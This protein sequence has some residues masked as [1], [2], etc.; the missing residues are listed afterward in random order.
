MTTDIP[1]IN[2][3]PISDVLTALPREKR[4][5]YQ[6][7]RDLGWQ[8]TSYKDALWH[9]YRVAIGEIEDEPPAPYN[10]RFPPRRVL[11]DQAEREEFEPIYNGR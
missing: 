7:A 9:D 4:S 11:H 8:F 6:A 5:S 2:G 10:P 3:V 1:K